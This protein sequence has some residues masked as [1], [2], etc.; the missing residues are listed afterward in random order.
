MSPTLDSSR[1]VIR[2]RIDGSSSSPTATQS[3]GGEVVFDSAPYFVPRLAARLAAVRSV[4]ASLDF[5]RP[6]T[7]D[8]VLGIRRGLTEA[9]K[10]LGSQ[11]SA[12]VFIER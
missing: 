10:E 12:I 9:R 11:I 8:L 5:D 6:Q 2:P 3:P 7:I 4:G 1:R